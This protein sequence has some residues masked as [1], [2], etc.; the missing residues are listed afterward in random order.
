MG[1][2][3]QQKLREGDVLIV[4]S[5]G[6]YDNMSDADLVQFIV[7]QDDPMTLAEQLGELASAR[8]VDKS[9][10]SPFMNAA[11]KAGVNWN[12]GKADDI[13]VVV[14]KV[15]DGSQGGTESLLST[16]PEAELAAE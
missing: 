4:A 5:D 1:Q 11:R 9:F 8:G 16:I 6:L 14:A 12:G 3:I 15:V 13:T 2:N 10:Q 7:K